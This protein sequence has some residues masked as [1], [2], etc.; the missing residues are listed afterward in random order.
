M[1]IPVDIDVFITVQIYGCFVFVSNAIY[2]PSYLYSQPIIF[3][4][5]EFFNMVQLKKINFADLSS[6][7][8]RYDSKNAIS[9]HNSL[10]WNNLVNLKSKVRICKKMFYSQVDG[11]IM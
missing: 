7:F 6:D 3:A 1:I 10:K 11:L 2:F 9:N 4:P 8:G 5:R